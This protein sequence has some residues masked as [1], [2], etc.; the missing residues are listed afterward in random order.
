VSIQ[1]KWSDELQKKVSVRISD[2]T[3]T[4]IPWAKRPNPFKDKSGL[5]MN[6]DF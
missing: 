5:N 3:S 6:I 1:E 2:K 4:E